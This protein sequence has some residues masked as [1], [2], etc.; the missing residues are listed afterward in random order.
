[1][2]KKPAVLVRSALV[3]FAIAMVVVPVLATPYSGDD[4]V[5]RNTWPNLGG[6][7]ESYQFAWQATGEWITV[8]GRFFPGSFALMAT[9]WTEVTTR[10]EYKILLVVLDLA[11][12]F[13]FGTVAWRLTKS[14]D[15]S[16]LAVAAL[17]P[18][19]QLRYWFDGWS[20]IHGL[21]PLTVLSVLAA[22]LFADTFV[23]TGRRRWLV[24]ALG[25]W[26]LGAVTYEVVLL[27][28]PT[29]VL[30]LGL[31]GWKAPRVRQ[32][33]LG[34]TSVAAILGLLAVL[35]RIGKTPSPPYQLA[36]TSD[37]LGAAWQQFTGA[38]PVSQYWSGAAPEGNLWLSAVPI[39]LVL[40]GV[41]LA[42][43]LIPREHL[44]RVG[45]RI[46]AQVAVAGAL[47]A[48]LPAALLGLNKQWQVALPTYVGQA[49]L[50]VGYQSIGVALF[51]LGVAWGLLGAS[52]KGAALGVRIAVAVVLAV[53]LSV[54]VAANA[55]F[56]SAQVAGEQLP[57]PVEQCKQLPDLC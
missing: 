3:A 20:Q 10:P 35:L 13:V 29:L 55:Q 15:L 22:L 11:V 45:W 5:N 6:L 56:V 49:Y 19:F 7:V 2:L 24:L 4:H 26:V 17:A 30:L 16:L 33:M 28:L 38:L 50:S 47:L 40:V 21:I 42:W 46:P 23:T 27:A 37:S 9:V 39:S 32:A 44:P 51:V 12:V 1:M 43:A 36:L 54:T 18:A 48:V 34:L 53:A 25:V 41:P 57:K 52:K 31:R 14:I 8:Q